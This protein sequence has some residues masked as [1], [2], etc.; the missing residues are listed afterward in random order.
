M[1][2]K[3]AQR[4]PPYV[5]GDNIVC[6]VTWKDTLDAALDPTAVQAVILRPDG[7]KTTLTYPHADLTKV[8]TGIYQLRHL[9]DQSGHW[10]IKFIGTDAKNSL[11]FNVPVAS[12]LT[13]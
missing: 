6:T 3:P 10:T 1:A 5:L 13:D 11:D 8:S 9:T 7:T 4:P 12:T 2:E